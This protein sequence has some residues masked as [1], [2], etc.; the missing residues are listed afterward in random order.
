M[1]LVSLGLVI[2]GTGGRLKYRKLRAH[3]VSGLSRGVEQSLAVAAAYHVPQRAS[4]LLPSR[5]L[6][7]RAP[8]PLLVCDSDGTGG[9]RGIPGSP[10]G[11]CGCASARIFLRRP[12]QWRLLCCLGGCMAFASAH[13]LC[14]ILEL[15]DSEDDVFPCIIL[16]FEGLYL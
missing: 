2:M 1:V 11:A 16:G 3:A 9:F 5:P 8:S 15:P 12:F 4:P 7:S 13:M 14:P 6:L 10:E